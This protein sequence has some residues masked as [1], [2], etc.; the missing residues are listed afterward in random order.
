MF[1]QLSRD[2][3]SDFVTLLSE[4]VTYYEYRLQKVHVAEWRKPGTAGLASGFA[5]ALRGMSLNNWFFSRFDRFW[6]LDILTE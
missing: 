6:T 3:F 5:C 4:W 2:L 1:S